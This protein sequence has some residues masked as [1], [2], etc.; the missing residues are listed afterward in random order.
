MLIGVVSDTHGHLPL[1][2]AA[3]DRLLQQS[4][5]HVLHCGDIGSTDIVSLFSHWPAH[6]VFGNVDW[7]RTEL[8]EAIEKS[9]QTC[10]DCFGSIELAGRRIGLLHGDDERRLHHEIASGNWDVICTGHTHVA[11]AQIV[12]ETLLVNPGAVY[13]S[14]PPSVAVIDLDSLQVRTVLLERVAQTA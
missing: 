11:G 8:G 7:N 10:H 9:G 4:V 5:H 1:T 12:N 13:R 6:F 14:Q 2:T 3:I